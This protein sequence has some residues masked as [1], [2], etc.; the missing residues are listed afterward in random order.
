MN[1]EATP[2]FLNE[3]NVETDGV[4]LLLNHSPSNPGAKKPKKQS[5]YRMLA[6]DPKIEKSEN[7]ISKI[8]RKNTSFQNTKRILTKMEDEKHE[9]DIKILQFQKAYDLLNE[10]KSVFDSSTSNQDLEIEENSEKIQATKEMKNKSISIE[11]EDQEKEQEEENESI[12]SNKNL[13]EET[14]EIFNKYFKE[15]Y[16]KTKLRLSREDRIK[17]IVWKIRRFKVLEF[18][19]DSNKRKKSKITDIILKNINGRVAGRLANRVLHALNILQK[20]KKK[21]SS[22][23]WKTNLLNNYYKS[24]DVRSGCLQQNEKS[25]L[26]SKYF[27]SSL[28]ETEKKVLEKESARYWIRVHKPEV[29]LGLKSRHEAFDEVSASEVINN[30]TA[31]LGGQGM[32]DSLI[33]IDSQ[34]QKPLENRS[35]LIQEAPLVKSEQRLDAFPATPKKST[36]NCRPHHLPAPRTLEL[37]DQGPQQAKHFDLPIGIQAIPRE[38]G[39]PLEGL[40]AEGS[41]DFEGFHFPDKGRR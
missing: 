35:S 1:S 20:L 37:A 16:E 28:I 29:S 21:L 3:H 10:L 26:S 34:A 13:K 8:K 40:F 36:L 4:N 9:L 18:I 5:I 38:A 23:S 32:Y 15:K 30:S 12:H 31:F 7:E 22:T 11:V 17:Q 19:Y 14:L 33:K 25:F 2:Y 24:L 39:Q 27:V 41:G 6:L